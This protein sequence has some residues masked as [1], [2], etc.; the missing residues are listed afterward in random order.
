MNINNE[1]K[2][3]KNILETNVILI[4]GMAGAG[5]TSFVHEFKKYCINKKNKSIY[6]INLDP[7]IKNVPFE[8]NFDIRNIVDYKKLMK[9]YQL[10]PNGSILTCLNMF[11]TK[12]NEFMQ[13]LKQKKTM[14]DHFIIDTPGQL[15]IFTWSISGEIIVQSVQNIFKSSIIILF[16]I[17][18]DQCQKDKSSFVTNI[19]YACN[20]ICKFYP[21]PFIIVFN[22]CDLLNAEND[23]YYDIFQW[24]QDKKKFNNDM[25]KDHEDN[26]QSAY[27][28]SIYRFME[29]FFKTISHV[30]VSCFSQKGFDDLDHLIYDV[31]LNEKNRNIQQIEKNND[32]DEIDIIMENVKNNNNND[33]DEEEDDENIIL[34]E[35]IQF[36]N[37]MKE[38]SLT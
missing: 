12:I 34:R 28:V 15:E 10:G 5:K 11:V 17:D 37:F 1:K 35:K 20:L 23:K 4:T 26:L 36:E 25:L 14:Y 27:G 21:I 22:K 3:L 19:L 16:V 29:K 7:V 13:K 33:E 38:L 31:L 6:C 8:M 2:I 30:Q 24:I 9:L 32:D 18:V